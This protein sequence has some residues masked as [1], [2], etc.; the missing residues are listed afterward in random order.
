MN[1]KQILD[2]NVA[3]LQNLQREQAVARIDRDWEV[4]RRSYY[5]KQRGG[6][7]RPTV[8]QGLFAAASALT[9][10]AL[11]TLSVSILTSYPV[12]LWLWIAGA[13]CVAWAMAKGFRTVVL[14]RKLIRAERAY[15]VRRQ[16]FVEAQT[17]GIG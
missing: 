16:D 2:A 1:N 5:L 17:N 14:A 11:W 7:L 4:E 15:L 10:G 13:V 9:F 12:N 6:E 3:V 8:T